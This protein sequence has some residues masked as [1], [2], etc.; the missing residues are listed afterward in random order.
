M[1]Y[2]LIGKDLRV[3]NGVSDLKLWPLFWG[4]VLGKKYFFASCRTDPSATVPPMRGALSRRL[5]SQSVFVLGSVFVH[6][7]GGM[8]R[9]NGDLSQ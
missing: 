5:Q 3:K 8:S 7:R 9:Q 4:R 2:A 1:Y 6:N